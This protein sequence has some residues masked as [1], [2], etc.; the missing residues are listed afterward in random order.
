MREGAKPVPSYSEQLSEYYFN[1]NTKR[2]PQEV[3][4]YSKLVI[5]DYL[6][7]AIG[8]ADVD[9]TKQVKQIF[10]DRSGECTVFN[11][12]KAPVERAA[13]INGAASH[14]L[15]MDDASFFAGGHPAVV[16]ISAALAMA[17]KQNSSG[18]ELMEAVILGYDMMTR[19]GRGV[20]P[21]H[22]FDR[23]W[24][25]TATNGIFGAALASAMLMKLDAKQM[26]NAWGIAYG[27]A[28]GN[29][30]CYAD[31]SM[32]KRL[33]PANAA[34]G[35]INAARLASVGYSG[36][37]WCFEGRH[38]YFTA[39]TDD[40][41]PERMLEN[42]DYSYYGIM[43]AAFKP[44]ACCRYNHAPVDSTLRI[45][46]EHELTAD[47]IEKVVVDICSM[48]VRAVVEPR[49]LKYSPENIAGAQ[50]S[51][52]YA[53]SCAVLYGNASVRQYTQEKIQSREVRDFIRKVE[54][55]HS[56]EMDRYLPDIIAAS[57]EIHTKDG[58]VF[59]EFTKFAKGDPENPMTDEECRD[60]FMAL[61]TMSVN[62]KR[63]WEIY[64]TV[65]KLD[66]LGDVHEL[67][68]LF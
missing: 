53:V 29:L 63:A 28:S 34:Q 37:R 33:N 21:D 39:F 14:A 50:F 43:N 47:D 48:A 11:G 4:D 5:L 58:R 13:F 61:A 6:G 30:E 32:T 3:L 56:G 65:M 17:E 35:G 67:T 12:G 41:T 55:I 44:H 62:E 22:C 8:G 18:R 24:H 68:R 19:V 36:P 49:E 25:P 23:G 15:E 66:K 46:R 51:L 7:C 20:V 60:K 2:I 54:M 16:I 31:A 42:M 27:F 45:I 52:P 38:G 40:P 64:D 26:A 57:A 10:M 59:K 1:I 9:T